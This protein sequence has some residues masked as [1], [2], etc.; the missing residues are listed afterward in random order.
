MEHRQEEGEIEVQL[1]SMGDVSARGIMAGLGYRGP[2]V[3]RP[4]ITPS[5][6]WLNLVKQLHY[7]RTYICIN[8]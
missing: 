6:C 8:R 4:L 1:V 5:F 2:V 3:I 7:V